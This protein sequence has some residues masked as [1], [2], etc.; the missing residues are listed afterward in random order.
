MQ[1]GNSMQMG[2]G[3][4]GRPDIIIKRK[5]RWAIRFVTPLGEIPYHYVKLSARPQLDI[6]ETEINF[7][8]ATTWIPAKGKWQPLSVTYIDTNAADMKPLYSWITS[9]HDFQDSVNLKNTEKS[10][11]NSRAELEMYDGCGTLMEQWTLYSCWIQSINFGDLDYSSTEEATIELQ[12]RYSEVNYK[13]FC[14]P[15]P[16]PVCAGC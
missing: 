12:I 3:K 2:I 16:S 8:N 6:E 7:L 1:R 14:G 9:I 15:N 13:S 4:L 5:F 10:G 11:W